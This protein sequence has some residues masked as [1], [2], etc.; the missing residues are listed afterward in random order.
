MILIVAALELK[1]K[2]RGSF[3]NG[4]IVTESKVVTFE[5]KNLN[6]WNAKIS[7][8]NKTAKEW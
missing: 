5:L 7:E 6:W 2:L 3:V 4:Q 1:T 8:M